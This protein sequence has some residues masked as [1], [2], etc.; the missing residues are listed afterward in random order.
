MAGAG[1]TLPPTAFDT[2]AAFAT[3]A[4]A[5]QA[6][7][8]VVDAL[9]VLARVGDCDGERV[10]TLHGMGAFPALLLPSRA[11]ALQALLRLCAADAF[12][13]K[14]GDADFK[15]LLNALLPMAAKDAAADRLLPMLGCTLHLLFRGASCRSL[16]GVKAADASEQAATS[17]SSRCRTRAR[18]SRARCS[19]SQPPG[20]TA[21]MRLKSRGCVKPSPLRSRRS[22][23]AAQRRRR[24]F[25]LGSS[26][27]DARLRAWE[28]SPPKLPVV[29]PVASTKSMGKTSPPAAPAAKVR[30]VAETCAR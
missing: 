9:I 28:R 3:S 23:S 11:D 15:A 17:P 29:S 26:A 1:A 25:S 18:S 2:L 21:G 14:L 7:G 10:A 13:S 20:M 19:A 16:S 5:Q 27:A 4:A 6:D 24:A 8:A 22:P 12:A 30:C